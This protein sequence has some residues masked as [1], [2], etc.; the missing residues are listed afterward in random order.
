MNYPLSRSLLSMYVYLCSTLCMLHINN[1]FIYSMFCVTFSI[2]QV[3][4]TDNYDIFTA[5]NMRYFKKCFR[6]Q[7]SICYMQLILNKTFH[8]IRTSSHMYMFTSVNTCTF[9]LSIIKEIKQSALQWFKHIK[10]STL[11]SVSPML[12]QQNVYHNFLS[13]KT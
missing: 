13:I 1:K 4:A 10:S 6:S 12:S 11:C 8:W 2:Q 9:F 5:G 3:L 7:S